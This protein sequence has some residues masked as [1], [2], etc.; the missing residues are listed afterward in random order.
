MK[1]LALPLLCAMLF[2]AP[3]GASAQDAG[4]KTNTVSTPSAAISREASRRCDPR[5]SD[6]RFTGN[7]RIVSLFAP[8]AP[9]RASG[10]QVTFDAGA[11][12]AWHTHPSVRR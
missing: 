11:R 1:T 7:V 10:G 12:T 2:S 4:A 6:D 5:G 8:T 9:S 3:W